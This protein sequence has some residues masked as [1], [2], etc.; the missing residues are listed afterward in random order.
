MNPELAVRERTKRRNQNREAELFREKVVG[1]EDIVGAEV[2]YEVCSC[3]LFLRLMHFLVS[4]FPSS[5]WNHGKKILGL[6]ALLAMCLF[7]L[8]KSSSRLFFPPH[9]A[10][11]SGLFN[12][13]I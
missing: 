2:Q 1:V 8:D 12:R 13:E 6:T 4:S 9:D 3:S 10:R 11:G 7:S 5:I